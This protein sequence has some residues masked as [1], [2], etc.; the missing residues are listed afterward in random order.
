MPS[1]SHRN[2]T[3]KRSLSGTEQRRIPSERREAH[4]PEV[5]QGKRLSGGR[6]R[7]IVAPRRATGL[8]TFGLQ[9]LAINVVEQALRSSPDVEVVEVLGPTG[10]LGTLSDGMPGAPNVIVAKMEPKTASILQQQG[11]GHLIVEEDQPLTLHGTVPQ[12]SMM[13]GS[14]ANA[15]TLTVNVVVIGR[16][17]APVANAEVYLYGSLLPAMGITDQQG[18][19][20]ISI[21]GE[22]VQSIRAVHVKPKADYWSFYQTRPAIDPTGPNIVGLTPLS[23]TFP[24]FPGQQMMGWGQRA[25]RL[26]KIPNEYRGQGVRIA[27]ID[28]GAATTHQNLKAIT[29]GLD[30]IEKAA[31]PNNWTVDVIAHGSHCAGVIAGHADAKSGVVGFAPASEI[32]ACK[33]FPGGQVSQLIDAL[34]YCIDK[35]IDLINL[36]LGTDQPSEALEQQLIRARNLGIACIVAAGN[37]GGRVQY[38][39]SSSAVLAVAAI[40]K[41]GEFPADSYHAQT[42]QGPTPDGYFSP[43]FTCFGEEIA[44]CAPGVAVLSSVPPDNFAVWDGTS[45]AT[46]HVTGLAALVLAHHPDFQGPFKTRN[47]QRVD[48]L[49]QT[50][51][52]SARWIDLADPRRTG[53]GMPDA[54]V[55]LGLQPAAVQ[56]GQLAPQGFFGNLLGQV[57]QPLG[58]AIGGLLGNQQLGGQ[59]G[60]AVGQLGRFLP[61]NLDPMTA[62]AAAAQQGQPTQ[63]YGNL[64]GQIGQP[65]GGTIGGYRFSQ[66][67]PAVWPIPVRHPFA[68]WW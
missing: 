4:M 45:M 6:A 25:M 26:D 19:V 18:E 42:V 63:G 60:G 23:E 40:G 5:P 57:G 31:N 27:I 41:L 44:V 17:N 48:R 37:S 39:A 24:N 55:A 53:F 14:V 68:A 11:Q 13:M 61:F 3:S 20:T 36:S 47:S 10:V 65:L 2:K 9:P 28:S 30:V 38:P 59:I 16:D 58:G 7:Y 43:R 34:E 15:P 12:P 64:F 46:P 29:R 56:Q 49:F 8:A 52:A 33:I 32:H 35:Q 54:P 1:G 22:T 66:P 51:K 50:L 62:A 21:V 67:L